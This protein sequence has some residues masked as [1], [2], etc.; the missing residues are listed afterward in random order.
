[1]GE[2]TLSLS[3][4]WQNFWE[5]YHRNKAQTKFKKQVDAL[6]SSN[7]N[8]QILEDLVNIATRQA[9]GFYCVVI[10]KDGVRIE[11][12]QKKDKTHLNPSDGT[13]W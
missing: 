2:L 9:P 11:M 10:M 3:Q 7:L 13:L 12:G 6:T 5:L 1:M 4:G 8:Y